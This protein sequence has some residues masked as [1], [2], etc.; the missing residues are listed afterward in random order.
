MPG[1]VPARPSAGPAIS[2]WS[3]TAPVAVRDGTG[4]AAGQLALT[5]SGRTVTLASLP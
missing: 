4:A 5:P 3:L 1:P 2:R